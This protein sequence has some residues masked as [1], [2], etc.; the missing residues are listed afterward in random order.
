MINEGIG[1]APIAVLATTSTRRIQ[2]ITDFAFLA[3]DIVKMILEG[4]Q[5][6]GLTSDWLK[7]NRLPNDWQAQR[8]LITTL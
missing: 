3:P 7:Y 6:I 8:V 5:P 1:F 2:T 4:R